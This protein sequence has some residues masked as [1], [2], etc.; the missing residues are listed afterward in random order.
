MKYIKFFIIL[1]ILLLVTSACGKEDNKM[2]IEISSSQTIIEL[3]T[4]LYSNSELLKIIDYDGSINELNKEYPIECIRKI[5]NNY[6]ISYQG[7]DCFAI[8]FYNN[9]NDKISSD[10]YKTLLTKDDFE[11][12]D[13]GQSLNNVQNLDPNG[14]YLFLFTGRN[15]TPRVSTHCT[16]DGYFITIEYSK[17]NIILN[18]TID[19]V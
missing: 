10:I 19:L 9:L 7:N 1:T 3:T 8:I 16:N 11:K 6:R 4:K 14:K 15:D 17:D 13:I 12:L 2:N 5:G 18:K